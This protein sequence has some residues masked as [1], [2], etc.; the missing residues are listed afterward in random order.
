MTVMKNK[1]NKYKGQVSSK[2]KFEKKLKRNA[3]SKGDQPTN[4]A[5]KR[6]NDK[7]RPSWALDD[8]FNNQVHFRFVK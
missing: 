3:K 8:N 2:T 1:S 5:V 6:L 4:P 7:H